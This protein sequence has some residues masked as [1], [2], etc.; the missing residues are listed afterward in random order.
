MHDHRNH[1]MTRRLVVKIVV[2]NIVVDYVVKKKRMDV[3]HAIVR[4]NQAVV[5]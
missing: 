1:P 4:S 3:N 2:K 5:F